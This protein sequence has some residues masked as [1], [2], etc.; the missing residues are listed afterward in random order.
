[1]AAPSDT[2]RRRKP[3][4]GRSKATVE[5]ILEATAQVLVADGYDKASTNRIAKVAGVS[6]GSVYQYFGG[7]EAL[8]TALAERHAAEMLDVMKAGLLD[9][10]DAPLPEVARAIV[11]TMVKAHAVDPALHSV[12]NEQV[13]RGRDIQHLGAE[14]DAAN[15]L[16]LRF[17]EHRRSELRVTDFEVASFVIVHTVE[18]L[19]HAAATERPEM[20]QDGR[21]EDALVDLLQRYAHNAA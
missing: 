11:R 13:P 7:K 17:L 5:A 1:M 14:I 12:L 9:L 10:L 15:E 20:L 16:L 8:V 19:I 4:Q 6:I 18:G 2:D 3:K 21:L